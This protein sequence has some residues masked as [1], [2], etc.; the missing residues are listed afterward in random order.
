MVGSFS[1]ARLR[2]LVFSV[3]A[4]QGAFAQGGKELL[5]WLHIYSPTGYFII[6]D[7]ET[8]ANMP[9]DHKQ[10]TEGQT[11][12]LGGV[13]VHETGHMRN[14]SLNNTGGMVSYHVGNLKDYKF[15][16]GFTPFSSAEIIPDFP[17]GLRNFQYETY[18]D[19]G[20]GMYSVGYGIL[21]I[22]EEWDQYVT[23]LKSAVEMAPCFKANFNSKADWDALAN[24]VTTSVWSNAEFRYFAL[25]YLMRAK[26][27][28]A[29]VYAQMTTSKELRECYTQLVQF[30]EQTMAEWIGVLTAQGMDTLTENGFDEH[31]KYWKEIQKQEYK[32]LEKIMLTAPVGVAQR[33]AARRAIDFHA[34]PAGLFDLRGRRVSPRSL[35]AE[36][37]L[38]LLRRR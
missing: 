28:H 38:K 21:G 8:R 19:G 4:A 22:M 30:A 15:K 26:Q 18:I 16:P 3:C 2:V 7:Y 35:E 11:L 10:W 9:G 32:D 29:G 12:P 14:L 31:W 37:F 24:D 1:R 6:D 36:G 25:R 34:A 23:D 17:A 33:I 5:E 27:S 13:A 20:E